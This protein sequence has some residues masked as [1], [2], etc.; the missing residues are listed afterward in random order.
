[1]HDLPDVLQAQAPLRDRRHR[2]ADVDTA[3]GYDIVCSIHTPQD[4]DSKR[5]SPFQE[6]QWVP[7]GLETL[8]LLLARCTPH[9]P[10][11]LWRAM[12]FNPQS[13][14]LPSGPC[15]GRRRIWCVTPTHLL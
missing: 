12:S 7:L 15:P 9:H 11:Q 6:Q 3:S 2:I 14:V 8:R 13:V 10:A 5:P 4:E 1:M